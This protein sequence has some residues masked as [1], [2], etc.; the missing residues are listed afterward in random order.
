VHLE[1]L[2]DLVYVQTPLINTTC[3]FCLN[4]DMLDM[5][6]CFLKGISAFNIQL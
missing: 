1:L 3:P 6:D 4:W 5:T 2:S